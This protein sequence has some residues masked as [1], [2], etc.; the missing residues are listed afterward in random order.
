LPSEEAGKDQVVAD[1]PDAFGGAADEFIILWLVV[2]QEAPC[3]EGAI[4][5]GSVENVHGGL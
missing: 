1:L 2:G 3:P 4:R 5:D